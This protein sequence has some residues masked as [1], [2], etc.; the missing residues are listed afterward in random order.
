MAR[1]GRF[2]P[3]SGQAG[4]GCEGRPAGLGE[5]TSESLGARTTGGGP[6]GL[7]RFRLA[8]EV[9]Y[10]SLPGQCHQHRH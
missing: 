5:V 7:P 2:S 4:P 3:L 8:F 6:R 10:S 9:V 1:T